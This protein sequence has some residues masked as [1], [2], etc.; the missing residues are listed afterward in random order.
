MDWTVIQRRVN[1]SVSFERSWDD[2]VAGFGDVDGNYWIGLQTMHELTSA[3][4]MSLQIDLEPYNIAYLEVN[5]QQFLIGDAAS[6]YQLTISGYSTTST[7]ATETFN[8]HSGFGFTTYDRDN[9]SNGGNCA[10]GSRGGWWFGSCYKVHL[11]GVYEYDTEVSSTMKMRH[12]SSA[13]MYE[14]LRK[15]TMKIRPA[16]S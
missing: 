1:A 13:V 5:Y 9:D 4:P 12:L 8:Y 11:N 14:P 3:Q 10:V 15:V 2:Y 6:Q 16:C 7:D